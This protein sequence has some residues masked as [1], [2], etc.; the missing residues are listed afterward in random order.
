L[1]LSALAFGQ[2]GQPTIPQ[3]PPA[4]EPTGQQSTPQQ[5]AKAAPARPKSVADAARASREA[6]EA[7]PPQKVYR[8]TDLTDGSDAG[9]IPGNAGV[10]VAP[11]A[12]T[13]PPRTASRPATRTADGI[14]LQKDRAFES[15]GNVFKRQILVQKTKII[16][17]QN[18]TQSLSG[19]FNAWSVRHSY[20]FNPAICWT[21][22][23]T[24][25]YIKD[26][27]EIGIRLQAA[28][29]TSQRQLAEEKERL[30]QMQEDIRHKGYGNAVYDPD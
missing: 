9:G 18:Q 12:R 2:A 11:P 8:N 3:Q 6:T 20:R 26:W 25:P 1:L 28:Y 15:Q 7:A 4:P 29:E 21:S 24:D 30:E 5:P 13:T 22:E 19:Q 17:L 10:P 14:S 16:T 23:Y 27:C